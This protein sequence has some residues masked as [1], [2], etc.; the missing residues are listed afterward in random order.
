MILTACKT[1]N[2]NKALSE[3]HGIQVE[4]MDKSVKPG[5]DFFRYV[6]GEWFDKTE[7]PADRTRWGSFDE[8][9]QNT[10]IDALAIL[11][12][13]VNNKKLDPKSDQMKAVNVFKTYLDLDTRNKLGIKPIQSTLEQINQVNNVNDV[14][15][16]L[17][18]KMPEGGLG[19]FWIIRKCRCY[20]F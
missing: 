16:L 3:G 17:K 12:E 18:E 8:L 6:N 14:V 1:Q 19:F 5:D 15:A 11:K 2:T 9:R 4:Y 10:D 13:A 7:I 20:E